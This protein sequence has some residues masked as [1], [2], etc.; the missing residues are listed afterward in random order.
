MAERPVFHS[1]LGTHLVRLREARGYGQRQAADIAARKGLEALSH[2]VIHRLEHGKVKHPDPEVLRQVAALY[3][4]DYEDLARRF[5]SAL[6]GISWE[7]ST[8]ETARQAAR[9]RRREVQDDAEQQWLDAW[10]DLDE[11]DRP[12]LLR[13]VETSL[14]AKRLRQQHPPSVRSQRKRVG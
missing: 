12:V 9:R 5:F 14:E 10:R 1:D 11:G 13:M 2:Q 4:V 8:S 7:V 6:Y 3:E